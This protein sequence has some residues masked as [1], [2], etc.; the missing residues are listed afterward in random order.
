[1]VGGSGGKKK[2]GKSVFSSLKSGIKKVGKGAVKTV[3][4]GVA[5]TKLAA[6]VANPI[7]KVKFLR[8]GIKG[9]GWVLPGSKYIGPGNRLDLG[10]PKSSADAAAFK[11]DL[12]YDRYLKQGHSKK[13][14]YAG[15]SDADHRLMKESDVTTPH[16]LATYL[17]MLPKKAA[18]SLGLTGSKIKD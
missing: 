11:H 3:K 17:G 14:V 9:E 4:V 18:Y 16:G 8:Q 5:A 10:K 2:K 12:A 15:Y 1:M 13:K 7:N 6:S